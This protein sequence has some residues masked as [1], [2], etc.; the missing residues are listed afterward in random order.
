MLLK[1]QSEVCLHT[2]YILQQPI[3]QTLH[4]DFSRVWFPTQLSI[5]IIYC[6]GKMSEGGL[7]D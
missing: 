3:Y 7:G 6:I 2:K 5:S 4:F 1:S